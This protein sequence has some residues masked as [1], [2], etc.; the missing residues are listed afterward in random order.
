MLHLPVA[1]LRW[2]KHIGKGPA[3][4]KLGR[5]L[6]YWRDEVLAWIEEQARLTHGLDAG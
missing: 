6:R 2:W 3:W 5:R 4:I 1:T